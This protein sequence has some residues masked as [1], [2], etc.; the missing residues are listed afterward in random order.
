MADRGLRVPREGEGFPERD[1]GITI[2]TT[3]IFFQTA[4]RRYVIIDAPGHKEFL[5]NAISGVAQAQAA[6][7]VIDAAEGVR[8]QTRRHALIL[9]LLGLR[10]IAVAVNKVDLIDFDQARFE[11]IA[12]EITD[13]LAQLK[14]TPTNIVPVS[15]RHGD[16]IATPS[17]KMLWYQGPTIL[18]AL[19]G[20]Q[21]APVA[22]DQP[23]RLPIQDVFKFDERRLVVGRIE[24]GSLRVGGLDIA[25]LSETERADW[26]AEH[27]GFIFQFYNLMPV[28]TAFGNVE[29]PLQLTSL[30]RSERRER[31]ETA[32]A[33]VGLSDRA[34]HLPNELSGGQQQ[35][36][37]I[38]RALITDPTLIVADE[39]T[40]DLDRTTAEEILALLERLN[41]EIGKTIIMVT[42][43]PKA[44]EKAHRLVHLEKGVLVD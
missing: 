23:L 10:Q 22:T 4:K 13:Y 32:L 5:K 33:L 40:G 7:L 43:D 15:A 14:L 28:L 2:D 30:S 25:S 36:V 27:V 39:P 6:I 31:V 20:F 16:N 3:Q 35:R 37:A 44:A 34:T 19:D 41:D 12:R 8:E 21:S 26:R 38:A 11:A 18:Q 29:L 42:H 1:Q 17:A 24:S 9:Q